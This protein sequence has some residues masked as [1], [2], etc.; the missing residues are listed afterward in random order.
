MTTPAPS[1]HSRRTGLSRLAS[2]LQANEVIESFARCPRAPGAHSR[3]AGYA[4]KIDG[5]W[6]RLPGLAPM[7]ALLADLWNGRR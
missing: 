1:L 4:V 5:T 2:V 3:P 7:E 6:T